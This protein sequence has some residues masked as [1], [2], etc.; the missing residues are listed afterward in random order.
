[1]SVYASLLG[2]VTLDAAAAARLRECSSWEWLDDAPEAALNG[3]TVTELK[4]GGVRLEF[5]GTSVRN[6]VRYLDVDLTA[7]AD[8]G[9]VTGTLTADCQD[10]MNQ[11]TVVAYGPNAVL[12][13]VTECFHEPVQALPARVRV[14]HAGGDF[15]LRFLVPASETVEPVTLTGAPTVSVCACDG[16]DDDDEPHCRTQDR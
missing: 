10:G 12:A 1:M 8:A 7:A 15:E 13:G 14:L 6:L 16:Y 2:S 11:R 5:D 3:I 4:S 9:L